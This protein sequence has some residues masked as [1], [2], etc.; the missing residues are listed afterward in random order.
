[1]NTQT[2]P[3]IGDRVRVV[4]VSTDAM[5]GYIGRVGTVEAPSQIP[6]GYQDHIS[7]RFDKAKRFR[8]V[9]AFFKPECLTAEIQEILDYQESSCKLLELQ[10]VE[11][12][13]GGQCS[14]DI[15]DPIADCE[16][17]TYA[18]GSAPGSH[19][20][21]LPPVGSKLSDSVRL[22]ASAATGSQTGF[23]ESSSIQTCDRSDWHF[24]QSMSSASQPP[25]SPLAMKGNA[26]EQKMSEIFSPTALQQSE[27]PSQDCSALK[28]FQ[29]S[30]AARSDRETSQAVS[31]NSYSGTF[32]AAG[33]MRSG[34][35]SGA[36][37]L[38]LPSLEED[39][40][41]LASPGALSSDVSRIPG[42]CKSESEWQKLGLLKK[43]EVANP[44]FL[45]SC[46]GLPKGW[47]S[48]QESRPATELLGQEEKSSEIRLILE[49]RRSQSQEFSTSTP[50]SVESQELIP[51][52]V[53]N[54]PDPTTA[55]YLKLTQI[56]VNGGTQ[57][58]AE[59]NLSVVEE[60]AE[61]MREGATFPPVIVYY[62]GEFYWLADGFHRVRAAARADI[63]RIAADI[64]QGTR[65]DA[66]LHS[67]GANACHGLRRTNADKKRAVETLLLDEEWGQWSDNAIAKA[68]GVSHPFVGKQRYGIFPSCNGYKMERTVQRNG[69]VYT[70]NTAKIGGKATVGGQEPAASDRR[71]SARFLESSA[72]LALK[73]RDRVQ[74]VDHPVFAGQRGTITGRPST[75]AAI[76]ALD[77][78]ERE[79]ILIR[80]LQPED[81]KPQDLVGEPEFKSKQLLPDMKRNGDTPQDTQT[82]VPAS[83]V[84]G[85]AIANGKPDVVA[86][87][88]AI[89]IKH[90]N[91]EGLLHVIQAIAH[92]VGVEVLGNLLVES[93][94][95]DE[96]ADLCNK[97][98]V[99]M[100]KRAFSWMEVEKMNFTGLSDSA[101]KLFVKESKRALNERYHPEYFNSK[102]CGSTLRKK[103]ASSTSA[104]AIRCGCEEDADEDLTLGVPS[105]DDEEAL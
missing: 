82:P 68:C 17:S 88:I 32:P 58:R 12:E 23:Q 71:T 53:S 59:I 105:G 21:C 8:A 2:R 80:Q 42:L 11:V 7:V 9:S 51:E 57:S 89:G 34:L 55:R 73:E 99:A 95:K 5:K 41:W 3:R 20:E 49:S 63:E 22:T 14:Q 83:L 44:D 67:V 40:C 74:V 28:M 25:V 93:I 69:T 56:K 16:L 62:D 76:V 18:V 6:R 1:M 33:T 104:P 79:R 54:Y 38:A 61:A 92:H 64:C 24:T 60:Y 77:E 72:V 29:D 100:D 50:S 27:T 85:S 19:L 65:R 48:P 30:S 97:C 103:S 39:C 90:L 96:V 43:G 75:D 13:V 86:A 87:E 52:S 81:L 45:E 47:T 36:E 84:N 35:V 15:V 37:T 4:T 78:G 10:K 26:E 70:Q 102:H 101:L 31:L 94:Y 46:F 66:V 91:R 98:L